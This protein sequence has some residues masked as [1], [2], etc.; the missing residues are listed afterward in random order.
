MVD[1]R[2]SFGVLSSR[3]AGEAIA[4]MQLKYM[5]TPEA[6]KK[7]KLQVSW[8]WGEGLPEKKLTHAEFS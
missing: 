4:S 1:V 8:V 7:I 3:N 2:P 5:G 6:L